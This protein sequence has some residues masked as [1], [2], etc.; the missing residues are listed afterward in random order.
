MKISI[1]TTA[2]LLAFSCAIARAD[3]IL[4]PTTVI[5][6]S[7]GEVGPRVSIGNV[8]DQMGITADSSNNNRYAASE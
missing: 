6:N 4:S 7:L 2:L 8:I 3:I 1:L 5:S